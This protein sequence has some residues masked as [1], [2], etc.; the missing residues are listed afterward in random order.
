M[1]I[2]MRPALTGCTDISMKRRVVGLSQRNGAITDTLLVR[3]LF[4]IF[5][6]SDAVSPSLMKLHKDFPITDIG[7]RREPALAIANGSQFLLTDSIR[8]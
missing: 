5:L 7:V 8:S 3:T 4:R 1:R 6:D 2:A